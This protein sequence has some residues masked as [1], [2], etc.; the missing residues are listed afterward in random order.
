MQIPFGYTKVETNDHQLILK[1]AIS[2]ITKTAA[3]AIE[4]KKNTDVQ[5]IQNTTKQYDTNTEAYTT[6]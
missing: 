6:P 5:S 4:K 1:S 2:E 3:T